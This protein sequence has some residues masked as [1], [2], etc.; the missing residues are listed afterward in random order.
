[1]HTRCTARIQDYQKKDYQNK[2]SRSLQ[3]KTAQE[4]PY[5]YGSADAQGF[6]ITAILANPPLKWERHKGLFHKILFGQRLRGLLLLN[7]AL[8]WRA[9]ALHV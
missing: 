8:I 6:S 2:E 9:S 7:I 3:D 1:M 4:M 5:D